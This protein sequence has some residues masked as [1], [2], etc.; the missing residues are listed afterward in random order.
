MQLLYVWT[1][2][3]I[4]SLWT[5]L[6]VVVLKDWMLP[7]NVWYSVMWMLPLNGIFLNLWM[8]PA[9]H[10]NVSYLWMVVHVNVSYLWME[11]FWT[12]ECYLL[13]M[14]NE[15]PIAECYLLFMWNEMPVVSCM[16][17]CSCQMKCCGS[18][19]AVAPYK[20]MLYTWLF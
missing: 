12:S 8:L 20:Y 15:I 9:V 6:V 1:E 13:F 10:V 4:F 5:K 18:M 7:L 11:S 3:L 14:C 17:V 2:C 19:Y 16:P